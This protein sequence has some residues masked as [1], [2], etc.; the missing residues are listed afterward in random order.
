VTLAYLARHGESDWNV[1]NRF[2]GVIDRPLTDRG[3]RQA[4]ELAEKL[5]DKDV[6]AV[7]SSPLR[8]ALDTA[9]IVAARYELE[10][11]Q[12]AGLRE[13]DVGSWAG[14]SRV[15]VQ[16][17]F[18]E[19][20]ERWLRGGHG[21]EDGESYDEMS[22][23][24]LAAVER[25]ARHHQGSDVLLVSHGGPI[26]AIH[27]AAAGMHVHEYRRIH[28]VEPNARLSAVAVEDGTFTRID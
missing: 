24:V 8:R 3:R 6:D 13:V 18:P 23:R 27:A 15:D 5:A 28:P 4:H 17:R 25:I 20:F 2:Q 7:Y 10:P 26:R 12:D 21:W 9:T 22:A 14:L 1:A 16:A 11:I 19:A